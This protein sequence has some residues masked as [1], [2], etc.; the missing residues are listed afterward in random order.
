MVGS[1]IVRR[2]AREDCQVITAGRETVDLRCQ[3]A[4]EDWMAENRPEVVF[5]A[6]ATIGG[7]HAN[8]GRPGEFIYDN[9]A[10]ETNIIHTAWKVGVRKLLFLGSTCVYPRLAPQPMTED[11]LLTGPL[12]PTN[13]WYAIAK[14]AGIKLCDA[15]RRQY[16]CDFISA[17]PTS[18]Y[19]PFDNFDLVSGHVLPALLR[20][21]H[22]AK[23]GG[24]ELVEIWGSGRPRREFLY[25]DDLADAVVFLMRYYSQEGHINVGTGKDVTIREV[26][27]MVAEAVGYEG[28][29]VFNPDKPDGAPRK[30]SDV[31]RLTA[32]GWTAKTDLRRG[33]A[34]IYHWF[35]ENVARSG[36]ARAD[37]DEIKR[38][39]AV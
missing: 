16:G 35:L 20:K 4:V 23:A 38:Q 6:A 27:E 21:V 22:E 15:F 18:L 39:A 33:I 3:A 34:K 32:L 29:F 12:E 13:Q 5:V 24:A 37:L 25:V 7:I 28:K 1:A 11:S 31:S 10:I 9:L 30:L 26:A 8:D 2:L 14:I 17:T 36:R 19:G